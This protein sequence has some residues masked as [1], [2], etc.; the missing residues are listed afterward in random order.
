M[1][2]FFFSYFYRIDK[3]LFFSEETDTS[4][5][6]ASKAYLTKSLQNANISRS[7]VLYIFIYIFY[8]DESK[9][10]LKTVDKKKKNSVGKN[11][12]RFLGISITFHKKFPFLCNGPFQINYVTSK[13]KDYR[14]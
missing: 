9:N 3:A 7:S 14:E 12:V 6:T 10:P 8:K 11:K 13:Q 4:H 2:F 5:I 1:N